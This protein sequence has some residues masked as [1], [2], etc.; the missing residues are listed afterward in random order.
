[1]E[2]KKAFD[3]RFLSLGLNVYLLSTAFYF[4]YKCIKIGWF[5]KFDWTCTPIDK[6]SSQEA[7]EV[8]NQLSLAII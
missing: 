5:W 6:S 7:L 3:T 2:K 4:A 1:M 8:I